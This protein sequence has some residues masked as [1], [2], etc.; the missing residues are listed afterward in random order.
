[1]SSNRKFVPWLQVALGVSG[2]LLCGFL[3]LRYGGEIDE[4][5]EQ[6]DHLA[7]EARVQ[8][9]VSHEVLSEWF[10]LLE[11]MD[12]TLATHDRTL[13]AAGRTGEQAQE[14]LEEWMESLEGIASTSENASRV[15]AKFASHLP[16]RIP[17][18]DVVNRDV[19]IDIPE[20]KLRSENVKL[21]YPTA[22]VGSRKVKIDVGLTDFEL[23]VPTLR[24]GT[25]SR[26]V[27]VPASPEL[28]TKKKTITVPGDVR[29][30]YQEILSEERTLL[31]D[32]AENLN[33][34][35]KAT[36]ESN[37]TLHNIEDLLSGEFADSLA[38]T[39]RSL[40]ESR[41][42]LQRSYRVELPELQKRLLR[43]GT[44]IEQSQNHFR[45]LQS[46]V[47]YLFVMMSFIP[48][49][50]LLSGVQNLRRSK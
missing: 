44:A 2:L 22:N 46:I 34:A 16:L 11:N 39:S 45:D 26:T 8:A 7:D 18:V 30:D 6:L 42:S 21:P 29:L 47:P 48:A 9:N 13:R 25:A 49:G 38:A 37:R 12:Q 36:R 40:S 10:T 23:D 1:M 50:I 32:T 33:R 43:G 15:F 41:G 31:K 27:S 14:S 24:V 3:Y 17:T 4:S 20:L 19:S 35:A 28:S 5:L